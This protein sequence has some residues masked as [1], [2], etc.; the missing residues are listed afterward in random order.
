MAPTE[1]REQIG[2]VH[3]DRDRTRAPSSPP[4]VCFVAPNAY[5]ALSG[6]K[7]LTNDGGAERQQVLLADELVRRGHRVSF[8]VLDHGDPRDEEIRGIRV[9]KCYRLDRGAPGL[10]FFYPR[11]TG[12]W[13]AMRRADADV[14]YQRCAETA[15]GLVGEWC[16]RHARGFIFATAHDADC[17][18]RLPLISRRHERLLYRY[19]LRLSSEVVAQTSR[20]QEM[21]MAEFGIAST[22]VQN[23]F[24]WHWGPAQDDGVFSG[25]GQ[26][27][28]D[29]LWAGRLSEEKRPDWVLR[30]ARELPGCR[31][32]M[33]GRC[34]SAYGRRV[35]AEAKSL[36]N[37]QWHGHVPHQKMVEL[38][39]SA[40]LLLCT[41]WGEGFPN[42]FLEAW[43]CRRGVLSTIDLDGVIAR[44]Q[45]GAVAAS[46]EEMKQHLMTL[47]EHG[48][49][50]EAAG[51]RGRRYVEAHHGVQRAGEALGEVIRRAAAQARAGG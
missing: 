13:S 38:Y 19:G 10:R 18:A 4:A 1:S 51:S 20:Q 50:W 35:V 39:Q 42:V 36:P 3:I 32:H 33:A 5:P 47:E 43:S 31:F 46:F 23:C 2:K 22:L 17:T 14:Y 6:R 24:V 41:S 40:R 16:R 28:R 21:L 48:E 27:P 25:S 45:T 15:T 29:I 9:L 11:L 7:D 12:L 8:I 34:D 49:F 26:Q 30:L 37:V 44:F